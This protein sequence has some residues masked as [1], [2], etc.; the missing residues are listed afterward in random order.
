MEENTF[1]RK[2]TMEDF[3]DDGETIN[4]SQSQNNKYNKNHSNNDNNVQK[5]Q[6]EF[7]H[8]KRIKP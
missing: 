4:Q 1:F 3:L 7:G 5:N 8:K 2:A 6:Q